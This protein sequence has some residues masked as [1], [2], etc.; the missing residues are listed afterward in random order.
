MSVA[1]GEARPRADTVV[2]R[3]NGLLQAA[4][5]LAP[6]AFLLVMAWRH[7]WV[8]EDAFLNF[9]VVEQI[10]AGHGPV[11]N[12]GER[13]EI[14]TSTLWLAMLAGARTA[15]P[16]VKIEYLSIAG[17]LLLTGLG[18]WL[19]ERGAMVLWQ[20]GKTRARLVVPFGVLVFV[21]LPPAWDWATSGLENGLSIAWLGALT[22]VVARVARRDAHLMP[23]P[24]TVAV[25]ALM[26]LGPLVRPDFAVV[27][28]VVIVAVLWA[29]RP[30]G[31]ELVWLIVGIVALPVAYEVFRAGYY[32]TLVPNT[33][34]AKHSSGTY[35]SQG[36]NY[37]LDLVATYWL[38]VPL[39]VVA[40]TAVLIASGRAPRPALVP[41]LALPVGGIL[42]ALFIVE[43]GG[44]YLHARLLLPSVFAVVAPFAVVP[45]RQRFLLPLLAVGIWALIAVAFLRPNINE[46]LV[47]YTDYGV[48]EGRT[49]MT[50]LAEPGHRPLLA[51]DFVF[52]DGIR[53]KRL[54]ERGARALVV[55]G[56]RPL[57][58]V[59]PDRTVLVASASGISG[60]LAGPDVVVQEVNSLGDPV[61]SRMPPTPRGT[62]GHRKRETW[63]WI[64][65]L[66]TRPGVGDDLDLD[67]LDRGPFPVPPLAPGEVAAARHALQCGAL[68]ELRDATRAP[69]GWERFWSNLTGAIGRTRLDVPRDTFAAEREFCPAP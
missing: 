10:R 50:A 45:W 25:G 29:R 33:A 22:L 36:W 37:F 6:I 40:A 16:F 5:L 7:R 55:T 46:G 17:S 1:I 24:R 43:S 59:T 64:L 69:L 9:R 23:V 35:W 42:H 39:A 58:D 52:D 19:A 15:L 18:L 38:W 66:T 51:T 48:A 28:V 32:G 53:A 4:L 13:V 12:A 62:P 60:F 14:F 26:G 2:R 8:E 11:F 34:L 41:M 20:P 31:S 21:A 67:R 47:P 56:A 30:R 49:L 63:P 54:Q 3:T 61:G 57:L 44:D 65:A 27:S 68:A